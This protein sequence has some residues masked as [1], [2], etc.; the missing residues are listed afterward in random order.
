MKNENRFGVGCLTGCLVPL[1]T[2]AAVVGFI[3]GPAPRTT[4]TQDED[5]DG[6]RNSRDHCPLTPMGAAVD[7][8]GCP[9]DSDGDGVADGIDNCAMTEFGELVNEIGCPRDSDGDRVYDGSDACPGDRLEAPV[10]LQ[11][12]GG[13]LHAAAADRPIEPQERVAELFALQAGADLIF[14]VSGRLQ[15]IE[16]VS[17]QVIQND[18]SRH[19]LARPYS[20]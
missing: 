9:L 14:D 2:T 1:I 13:D 8:R 6:V 4:G 20:E 16:T 19:R 10:T 12:V 17:G 7:R 15:K 18:D 5:R 3:W 11:H